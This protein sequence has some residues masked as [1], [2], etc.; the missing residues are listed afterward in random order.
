[1]AGFA[2]PEA[3]VLLLPWPASAE[4]GGPAQ[5]PAGGELAAAREAVRALG[6]S[7][8]IVHLAAADRATAAKASRPFWADLVTDRPHPAP[9][10]SPPPSLIPARP[11]GAAGTAV[12]DSAGIADLV[13][14][15]LPPHQAGGGSLDRVA[16]VAARLLTV[17][18]ILAVY[19]HSDWYQGRLVDPT[20]AMVAAGQNADL[21]Y[22]QHI[23]T[24]HTPIRDGHLHPAATPA[25][26]ED[27]ARARHRAQLRDLPAPHAHAHGDVLVFAQPHD[28]H[29][30]PSTPPGRHDERGPVD[31]AEIR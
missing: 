18:G 3:R 20:G 28:H 17:G 16:L 25:E 23:V 15:A 13:I 4:A 19:T 14:T 29:D 26:A 2:H 31:P 11:A 8:E 1:M 27:Y 10:T 22:L 7:C 6:R 9:G 30:L 5:P 24:L 21:L 12:G